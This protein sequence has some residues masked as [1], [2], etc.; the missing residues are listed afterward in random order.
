MTNC[1]DQTLI[2]EL[3]TLKHVAENDGIQF[4]IALDEND[5]KKYNLNDNSNNN[6]NNNSNRKRKLN[7]NEDDNKLEPPMKKQKLN[8]NETKDKSENKNELNNMEFY[9]PITMEIMNDPV[10]IAD[11]ATYERDAIEDWFKNNDTSPNSGLK[12]IHKNVVTN[13]ALKSLIQKNQRKK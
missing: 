3:K 9:C 13:Y 5:E 12:L 2:N 6:N 4:N 11:G 8:E 1:Y 10:I 7:E